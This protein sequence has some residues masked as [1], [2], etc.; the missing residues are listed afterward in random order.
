VREVLEAAIANGD[1]E[2]PDG[3]SFGFAGS[4]ENALR[5]EARLRVLVP[6]VLLTIMILLYLQFRSFLTTAIVFTGIAVALAGGF[7]MLWLYGRPG[8]LDVSLLGANLR[9]V[10]QVG[11]INLS[12]AVWVGFIAL[13]GIATDDG[14]VMATRLKQRFDEGPCSSVADVR[15]RVIEAGARRVRPCLMTTA[16]TIL[17]LLP[18]LTSYGTGSDVM[19]PMAV[20]VLGGM[21]IALVTLFVVPLLY[22]FVEESR[23]R[24]L[25][26]LQNPTISGEPE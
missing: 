21:S 20:P 19:I 25:E 23:V 11:P 17:A 8:F 15:D 6:V 4:Y 18:I 5:A 22:S 2:L 3:V 10:F 26:F 12:V 24:I 1:L 13:F 9:E 14:V 16:T 7:I